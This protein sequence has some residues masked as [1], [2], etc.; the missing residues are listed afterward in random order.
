M[1]KL[2]GTDGMRGVAGDY[3]LDPPTI[4]AL[5]RALI[6]LLRTEGLPARVLIG[7]DT[8]ESGG[9]IE[10]VLARGIRA[11]DG[12]AF[13][14]G[15]IP[16]SGVSYLTRRHSFSAGIVISA[17]HNP[18]RDNGIKIFSSEGFK[19]P[20]AWEIRLEQSLLDRTGTVKPKPRA[21]GL[22]ADHYAHDY[23]NSSSIGSTGSSPPAG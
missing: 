20:D 5:G 9:W 14:A 8:R 2:F 3:P 6:E 12:A 4:H 18:F 21:D 23:G 22:S 16:T 19:I 17:S 10:D 13:S 15:I 1:K 11:A 7:R